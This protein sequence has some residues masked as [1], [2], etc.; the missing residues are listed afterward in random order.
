MKI[1]VDKYKYS[2]KNTN[3]NNKSTYISKITNN[4]MVKY[5]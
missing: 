2:G 5:K 1:I 4:K 3:I